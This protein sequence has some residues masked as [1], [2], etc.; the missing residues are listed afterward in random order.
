MIKALLSN[1]KIDKFE[2]VN[3]KTITQ[4]ENKDFYIQKTINRIIEIKNTPVEE[5]EDTD[6][7]STED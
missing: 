2:K 3:I 5:D 7:E 6:E 4:L 1:H